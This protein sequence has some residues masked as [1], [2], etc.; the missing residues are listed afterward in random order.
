MKP[1]LLRALLA[2]ALFAPQ[3]TAVAH[4]LE[5]ARHEANHP[6]CLSA[7]THVEPSSGH[8]HHD[9]DNC[10]QCPRRVQGGV[11]TAPA[12]RTPA[13]SSFIR[14]HGVGLPA[15]ASPL[16]RPSRGPPPPLA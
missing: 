7:G 3:A 13:P 6:V 15:V 1:M 4:A 9:E 8:Q 2:V 16:P 12:L 10:A 5:T 11:Q 14:P